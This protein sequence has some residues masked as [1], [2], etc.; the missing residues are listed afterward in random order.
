MLIV[1]WMCCWRRK[2]FFHSL[3][4]GTRKFHR[5]V[6]EC[7]SFGK[8]MLPSKTRCMCCCTIPDGRRRLAT[9]VIWF[10]FEY[11]SSC[12]FIY[13]RQTKNIELPQSHENFTW[14][15][16]FHSISTSNARWMNLFNESSDT[17]WCGPSSMGDSLC[18][19][20]WDFIAFMNLLNFAKGIPAALLSIFGGISQEFDN[21]SRNVKIMLT[22]F[23][24][25]QW[26]CVKT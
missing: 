2:V 15:R 10:W 16:D 3:S 8:L 17:R 20:F 24:R 1:D 26:K 18:Y 9:S 11:G 5:W 7:F 4:Q 6:C 19:E 22:H 12:D 14:M 21:R 23:L 25:E 13:S